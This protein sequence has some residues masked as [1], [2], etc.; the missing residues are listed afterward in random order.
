MI[1]GISRALDTNPGTSLEVVTSAR[2]VKHLDL[3]SADGQN[4]P[5]PQARAKAF[6][7]SD[8]P[9]DVWSAG[10]NS[11]SFCRCVIDSSMFGMARPYHHGH[12][13]EEVETCSGA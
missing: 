6:A 7:R 5:L 2:N 8:V 11:T 13:I 9:S 10:I 4:S 12:R 3:S 1:K